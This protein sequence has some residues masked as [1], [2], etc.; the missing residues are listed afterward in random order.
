MCSVV[1]RDFERLKIVSRRDVHTAEFDINHH[2]PRRTYFSFCLYIF[3]Q[4]FCRYSVVGSETFC[5]SSSRVAEDATHAP[6]LR[7][8]THFCVEGGKVG[9]TQFSDG[10]DW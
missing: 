6:F 1:S 10:I 2:A 7:G 9:C 3:F 5:F 8:W 4:G